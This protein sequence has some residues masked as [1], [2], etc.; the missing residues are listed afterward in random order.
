MIELSPWLRALLA[1]FSLAAG[2]TD[3]RRRLIP[4]YITIPAL[5]A[6]F[7]LQTAQHG[8]A[9]LKDASLGMAAAAAITIPLYLLRGLGGG[10]VKMMAAAGA[11]AGPLNFLYL[12]VLNAVIG[13]VG[14]VALVLYKAALWPRCATW[15]SFSAKWQC[16]GRRI[17]AARSSLSRIRKRSRCRV[18]SSL[19]RRR[20]CCCFC[21][22]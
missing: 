19:R 13:G 1:L 14:A 11:I 5:A 4:N 8:L 10:D 9:G 21:D 18:A 17:R 15:P 16:C 6:G 7:L 12:F 2:V 3:W 20:D 22:Q